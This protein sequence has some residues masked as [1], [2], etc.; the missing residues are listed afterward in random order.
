MPKI[1]PR[2]TVVNALKRSINV[3]QQQVKP[4]VERLFLAYEKTHT[5]F[6]GLSCFHF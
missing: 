1:L 2:K 3:S 6:I 4:W 5:R